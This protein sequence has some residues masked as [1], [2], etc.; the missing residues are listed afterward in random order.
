MDSSLRSSAPDP[1][2]WIIQCTL[3]WRTPLFE[4]GFETKPLLRRIDGVIQ[5]R[6]NVD[7]TF[8][9][10]VRSGRSK[11]DHHGSSLLEN[12]YHVVCLAEIDLKSSHRVF[13]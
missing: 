9:S 7:L 8:D 10:L 12:P 11:G 13:I 5:E 1:E 4:S 6:T 3:A 2:M